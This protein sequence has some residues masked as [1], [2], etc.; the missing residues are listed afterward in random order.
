MKSPEITE[1]EHG[2]A[3]AIFTIGLGRGFS[4]ELYERQDYIEFLQQYQRDLWTDKECQLPAMVED[5]EFVSGNLRE[6]HLRF[7]FLNLPQNNLGDTFY[8]E[9]SKLARQMMFHFEQKR[10]VLQLGSKVQILQTTDDMD[11]KS[12]G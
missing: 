6:P 10:T 2:P 7:N 9:V 5:C 11:P 8:S 12:R 1:L 4:G 3:S